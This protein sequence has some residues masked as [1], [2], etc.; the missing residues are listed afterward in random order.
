MKRD[1]NV[2]VTGGAGYIGSHMLRVLLERGYRPVVF[3]NLSTGHRHFVPRGV[4]FFKGDLRDKNDIRRCLRRHPVGTVMDFAASIVVPESVADPLKYY[5]N[6]VLSSVNLLQA[7][8]EREVGRFVFSS[9][10]A[11][12]GEPKKVPI[13]EDALLSPAN[14]YGGSKKMVEEILENTARA[15][16]FRYVSLRY[17]NV[18]GSHPSGEIGIDY[19][20]VTHLIPS[21][22]KVA[23]GERK[24]F[25]VFGDKYPTPDGTC[26]R[27]FIYVMDLCAAHLAALRYLERGGRSDVFNL[28]NGSGYSVSQVLKACE[29]VTGRRIPVKVTPARP[30]D[31]A[32]VVASSRKAQ[33]ILG[34]KPKADLEFVIRTAWKWEQTVR[35]K[36]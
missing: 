12:Y 15:Y 1:K 34:W 16:P 8:R 32:R 17:F 24:E 22:L 7:M 33:R 31:P 36:K 25:L 5:E 3:D 6:N 29:K 23:S 18:A 10:A 14:P 21:V 2:L 26:V 11:V 30:G 19:E 13:A 20:T 4:P 35:A 9:T 28:G 27:D